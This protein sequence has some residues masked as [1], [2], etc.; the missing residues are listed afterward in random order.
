MAKL[1]GAILTF[2]SGFNK[3]AA[4]S[5][6]GLGGLDFLVLFLT[7]VSLGRLSARDEC[8]LGRA[9]QEGYICVTRQLELS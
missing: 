2:D 8:N 3:T 4:M 1:G 7:F 5:V 6:R 9:Y